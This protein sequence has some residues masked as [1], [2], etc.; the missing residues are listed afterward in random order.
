[1]KKNSIYLAISG[2]ILT[3]GALVFAASCHK[4]AA[5]TEDVGYASEQAV[6]DKTLNDVSSISDQAATLTSGSSMNYR[7][8]S[9]T[10][11]GCATVTKDSTVSG[12]V[13]T[14]TIIIDFGTTDCLGLDG[15]YRR[16][17]I[18]VTHTGHYAYSGSIR[19]ITFNN[20]YQND[21]K[22]EGSKTVQNMGHN[23]LGQ[24]YFDVT[25]NSTI[26]MV[27]GAVKLANWTRVRT[28][29]A[30]YTNDS[31]RSG[32]VYSI[33]GT[34]TLTRANGTVVNCNIP[35]ATPLIVAHSC[36]W[37]EAGT[38]VYTLP[39]GKTRI[40]NYGNTPS[41]DDMATDTLPNGTTRNITLP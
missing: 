20:F 12:G 18:I 17:Q 16:G 19:T 8:A 15:R 7:T 27:T 1:M 11:G 41:C 29:T 6:A 33:T 31:D 37:I 24:P 25:I 30:G 3:I 39:D 26:T 22:V 28:W 38:I 9:T 5:T 14:Y 40:L 21:N 2:T 13:T 4:T 23:S 36:K 32:D 34:G 35:V 10:L